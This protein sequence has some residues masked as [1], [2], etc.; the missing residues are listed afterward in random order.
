MFDRPDGGDG[1]R[2]TGECLL[3]QSR[4]V[5]GEA[6]QEWAAVIAAGVFGLADI[7]TLLAQAEKTTFLMHPVQNPVFGDAAVLVF[8]ELFT[9]IAP[10]ALWRDDLDTNIRRAVHVGIMQRAGVAVEDDL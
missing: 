2:R 9:V 8:F 10:D 7:N 6:G 3:P 5:Q 1:G 4:D